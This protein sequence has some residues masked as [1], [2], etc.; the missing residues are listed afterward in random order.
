MTAITWTSAVSSDWATTADWNPASIPGAGDD[1]TIA[2]NTAAYT[3]TIGSSEAVDSVTLNASNATLEVERTLTLGGVLT[4]AAGKLELVGGGTIAGGTIAA[5]GGSLATSNG[6]L[7]G[8]TYQGTLDLSATSA[9]LTIIDGIT[10]TGAGGTGPG[11]INLTGLASN[12]FIDNA[13]TLDNATINLGN[14]SGNATL[15]NSDP[16]ATG[17]VLTLGSQLA[18]VQAGANARLQS[19]A[20]AGDGIVN[21]GTISAGIS[22][23]N[24]TVD[25]RSFTNQ[26]SIAISNGAGFT[27]GTTNFANAGTITVTATGGPWGPWQP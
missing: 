19:G 23:G 14:A 18:L 11:T 13:T 15:T 2:V 22:H 8:V 10:L 20:S 3:L 16:A 12:L 21:L 6:T 5:A 25:G 27:D 1:V 7:N 24:F 26:G 17:A 9:S 4:L